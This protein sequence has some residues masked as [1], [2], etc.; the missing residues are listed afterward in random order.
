MTLSL[1]DTFFVAYR[2]DPSF[3]V[4]YAAEIS[5][6]GF[7]ASAL[8]VVIA[9]YQIATAKAENTPPKKRPAKRPARPK[10]DGEPT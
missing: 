6:A 3:L 8:G 4:Q 10:A 1:T 2:D 7:L 9:A 5:F